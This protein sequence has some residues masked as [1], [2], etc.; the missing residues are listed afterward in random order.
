MG[1][2]IC[3]QDWSQEWSEEVCAGMNFLGVEN[4]WNS[5]LVASEYFL[6]NGSLTV[7]DV[8]HVQEARSNY[9]QPCG[10][11]A[12]SF[13]CQSYS[14][15]K[16]PL[17]EN[18]T[19]K[20]AGEN[21]SWTERWQSLAYLIHVK[22][23]TTC[24]ATIIGP[25]WLI[26]SQSCIAKTDLNSLD[27]A[28]VGGPSGENETYETQI[29]AVNRIVKHPFSSKMRGLFRNDLALIE[30]THSFE[31]DEFVQPICLGEAE[32]QNGDMCVIAGWNERQNEGVSFYQYLEHIPVP[33]VDM[34]K[35]NSTE[36]YNGLLEDSHICSGARADRPT[37]K[38]DTGAPLMCLDEA[39]SWKLVGI[40][41]REGE[42][43]A[44]S[45]PDVFTST[46]NWND[47][48]AKTIGRKMP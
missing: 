26:T 1:G 19:A 3:G 34:N 6:L 11:D 42:C 28:V 12:I 25:R 29:K 5:S 33:Y 39:G 22:D 47:W 8:S 17:S 44:K 18:L 40:L 14:C 43:L 23:R 4:S 32:P 9:I 21:V 20:L 48:I 15:G 7:D 16:W 2:P 24:T 46:V 13:Q 45:H 36:H 27:W 35:C 10:T 37:C 31:F 38:G 41:S 30:L